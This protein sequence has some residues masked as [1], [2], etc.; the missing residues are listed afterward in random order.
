MLG[1]TISDETELG[2]IKKNFFSLSG[3]NLTLKKTGTFAKAVAPTMFGGRNVKSPLFE[4]KRVRLLKKEHFI[5][6]DLV[7]LATTT[8][9]NSTSGREKTLLTLAPTKG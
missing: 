7:L 3:T 9:L 4:A 5:I 2:K 8:N 1:K 6:G